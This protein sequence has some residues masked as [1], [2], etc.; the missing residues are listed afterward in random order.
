MTGGRERTRFLPSLDHDRVCPTTVIAALPLD[1]NWQVPA[2]GP[3]GT[4]CHAEDGLLCLG[5]VVDTP[6]S[7]FLAGNGRQTESGIGAVGKAYRTFSKALG[8]CQNYAATILAAG[9]ERQDLPKP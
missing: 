9:M 1:T 2:A 6:P 4:R 8:A 5:L 3:R 7:H